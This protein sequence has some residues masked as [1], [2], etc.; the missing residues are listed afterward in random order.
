MRQPSETP[1]LAPKPRLRVV[2]S[3]EASRP[4]IPAMADECDGDD[5]FV[6]VGA[7]H[8]EDELPPFDPPDAED[9]L[10]MMDQEN[11]EEAE[12]PPVVTTHALEDVEP[13]PEFV[14]EELELVSAIAPVEEALVLDAVENG[15]ATITTIDEDDVP[16]DPP[17]DEA[18]AVFVR[19]AVLDDLLPAPEVRPPAPANENREPHPIAKFARAP[20]PNYGVAPP[21]SIH[22]SWDRAETGAVGASMGE[23]PRMSRAEITSERGGLDGAAVKFATEDAPDLLVVDTTLSGQAMFKALA[24]LRSVL[25]PE[26]KLV[27]IGAI[28]DVRL[29]RELATR[30]VNEYVVAPVQA[31]QL[32][33]TAC[34]LFAETDS[35][36]VIAVIGARG[37]VGASAIARNL[38]WSIAEQ[39]QIP[40]A[41]VDLDLSFGTAAFDVHVETPRSVAELLSESDD[42]ALPE[43]VSARCTERLRILRAPADLREEGSP[44]PEA[45]ERMVRAVRRLSPFVILDLPHAW[46]SWV[47]QALVSADEVIVVASPDLAS[48]RNGEAML[49]LLKNDRGGRAEPLVALS[50]VG[51]PKRPEITFKDFSESLKSAPVASFAFDPE[52]F[53]LAALKG[54]M[55]TEVA[56]RSKAAES[57]TKLSSLLTGREPPKQKKKDLR[58]VLVET[59]TA[60][61]TTDTSN[62]SKDAPE[63]AP[64]ELTQAAPPVAEYILRARQAAEA[65]M[66]APV[67][68]REEPR[69]DYKPPI[70]LVKAAA[71]VLAFAA[72][73][74]WYKEPDNAAPQ[75]IAAIT[76]AEAEP[77]IVVLAQRTGETPARYQAAL[78][79]LQADNAVDAVALLR[80]LAGENY[81]PAQFRLAKAYE[82]GE[83]VR[84]DV[85]SAR[86]WTERAASNG[87]VRAMHDLGVYN[88]MGQGAPA[89]EAA[90]FR[91]FRQA[92]EYGLADSQ[93]NLGLLYQQGRGVTQSAD[94]ALFWFSLAA[95]QGDEAAIQRAA[96]IEEAV[97][98]VQREQARARAEAFAARAPDPR[99]NAAPQVMQAERVAEPADAPT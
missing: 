12:L 45:V 94:E 35:S 56:P 47:K 50:M 11:T 54:Q 64:L 69:Q 93:Y 63:E 57:F 1:V 75:A 76:A 96:A 20:A 61:E 73:V 17:D 24:R 22:I 60:P 97:S 70:H 87:N 31:G 26:T 55:V 59:P 32:V 52:L 82:R 41:L 10:A 58:T 7:A 53:G 89:D 78:S 25:K 99:A 23:D 88:A 51:V 6:G 81:A 65:E 4:H 77:A 30:G 16:F 13:A 36:R 90:A 34:A 49:R 33:A 8:F 2:A 91:W 83:G 85:S 21:I 98:D 18:P 84:A 27:V 38:A 86:Q 42:D 9:L 44:D 15:G 28:N 72:G 43:S 46:T 19:A 14:E 40:T 79:L 37:G 67:R 68:Q 39:H 29:F 5:V 74:A 48:L 71:C 92:A 62:E 66:L 3:L 80:E 95:R